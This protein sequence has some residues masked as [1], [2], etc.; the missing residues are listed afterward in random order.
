MHSN[1]YYSKS[2]LECQASNA[3]DPSSADTKT[4]KGLK[5]HYLACS[6]SSASWSIGWSCVCR[7]EATSKQLEDLQNY[8]NNSDDEVR[9]LRAEKAKLE[10]DKRKLQVRKNSFGPDILG[11]V[12]TFVAAISYFLYE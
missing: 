5:Y 6:Q 7:L 4:R 2:G 1:L 11:F 10:N 9:N 12:A 8:G 3:K